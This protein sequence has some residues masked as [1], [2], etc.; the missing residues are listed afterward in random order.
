MNKTFSVL[1]ILL[2]LCPAWAAAGSL[3][4][5]LPREVTVQSSTVSLGDIAIMSGD[6][7][8]AQAAGGVSLGS[9]TTDGQ[10]LQLDRAVI[11]SRLASE[12]IGRSAVRLTGAQR[13]KVSRQQKSIAAEQ[14]IEGARRYL[15]KHFESSGWARLEQ[16]GSCDDLLVDSEVEK[17]ELY[18]RLLDADSRSASVEVDVHADGRKIDQRTVRFRAK[19]ERRVAVTTRPIS[20]GDTLTPENVR[21]K[22]ELSDSPEPAHWQSPYGLVASRSLRANTTVDSNLSSRAQPPKVIERNDSVVIRIQGNGFAVSAT[23][24][25]LQQGRVG[26]Q[27]WVRNTDSQR[28]LLARVREDGSV[29]PVH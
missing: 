17:V 24:Q 4:V 25:A 5:Y 13:V 12:G 19:F 26:Q 2:T 21:I 22:T 10:Q 15:K 14:I 29:E 8:L 28:R 20:R 16:A 1:I 11:M 7:S 9:F 6:N 18:Y 23:G 3:N 27:I